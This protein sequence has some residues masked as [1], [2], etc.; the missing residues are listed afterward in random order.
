MQRAQQRYREQAILSASPERLVV[1]LYDRLL[2]DVERGEAALT[3]GDFTA[4]NEQLQ[5]AQAIV[6]ELAST[7]NVEAWEG[8]ADLAAL[9]A[10]LQTELVTANIKRDAAKAAHCKGIVS[11]LRDAFRGAAEKVAGAAS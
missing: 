9:Y 10:H 8:A 2:L 6:T 4:A 3:A 11:Q 7:L 1:M 5:H